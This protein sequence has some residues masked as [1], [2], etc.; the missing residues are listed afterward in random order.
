MVQWG[1]DSR[2]ENGLGYANA[3]FFDTATFG[4]S[5]GQLWTLRFHRPGELDVNGKVTNWYGARSFQ[6]GGR[7]AESL[8]WAHPFFYLTANTALPGEYIY[9]AYLGTGDRFNLLDKGGGTCGPGNIRACSM[10]GCRVDVELASN[11]SETPE[12]G[13]LAGSQAELNK[14]DLTS[15]SQYTTGGTAT[16]TKARIVV[17]G[18]PS[19]A[20]SGGATGF[21]KAIAVDCGADVA[22]RWGCEKSGPGHPEDLDLSNTNNVPATRNWYFSVR[23]FED[24][25]SKRFPFATEEEAKDY[26]ENRLWIRDTGSAI[27]QTHAGSGGFSIMSASA[28]NPAST[29]DAFSDGWAIYYDHGP[30][31]IADGKTYDTFATDERTSSVSGLYGIVTWNTTQPVMSETGAVVANSCFPSKC[32]VGAGEEPRLAYHYAA[33]PL[34]GKS[35]LEDATG[36]KIRSNVSSSYVPAQGDQPTIFVNQ[37]GQVLVGMT[38]VNPNKG[39]RSIAATDPS[40]AVKDLGWI[41]VSEPLHACRHATARPAD[42][43]CR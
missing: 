19:P 5:G 14:G 40:D 12:L 11:F 17:S 31:A 34:T 24:Q 13:K 27:D 43:V 30:T 42:G 7:I 21:T 23:V 9:R 39:A 35:V 16:G 36:A 38:V 4:D 10:R 29:A 33:H 3:G 6:M 28:Q 8:G 37:K 18:C 41:E 1:P 22:G 25:P 2:R 32:A 15:S 20:V 26:D